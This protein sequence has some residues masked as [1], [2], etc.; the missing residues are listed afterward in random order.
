MLIATAAMFAASCA[1]ESPQPRVAANAEA[2]TAYPMPKVGVDGTSLTLDGRKWW[3]I[4]INAYQLGTNWDINAGCGAQ[5][6]LDQYFGSLAPHSLTRINIYSSFAVNKRTGQ[7]DLS[8]LDAIFEAALRHNQLLIAVLSGGEGGCENGWFKDY[9]WY[10][11]G[12]KHEVPHEL[13]MP[14]ADWLELAVN[15]W[16]NSPALAGWTAVGEPEPSKCTDSECTWAARFCPADSAAVL[17]SFFDEVG[18]KIRTLDPDALL[19]SG[20]TGGGQ[21]GSVGEDYEMVAA[22]PGIDVV[23]YHYYQ[24]TDYL[25]GDARDGLQRRIEQAHELNKPLMVAEVGV[26]AGAPCKSLTQ[27]EQEISLIVGA[28]RAHGAAGVMFWSYV[29]DPRLSECTLDIGPNDP[30]FR[31]I[32]AAGA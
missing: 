26:E 9:D 13:P 10:A 3:P 23:E 19:F 31:M 24:A 12:W 17:R 8:S 32:G 14:F 4:G 28:Q 7:L 5:V 16:G 29:P 20:H 30:L 1:P 27:R 25:P 11:G 18:A 22:S 2:T 15:R 6:D 21:C